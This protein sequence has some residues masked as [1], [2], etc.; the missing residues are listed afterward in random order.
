[1]T[2]PIDRD[3]RQLLA[4][5]GKAGLTTLTAQ[6]IGVNLGLVGV[7]AAQGVKVHAL[8]LRDHCR[9]A[10]LQ[11]EGPCLR[12]TARRCRHPSQGLAKPPDFVMI[13][14]DVAHH[15]EQDQMDKGKRI[16][17]QLKAPIR[18]IP[19]E[20]DWYLDMGAAWRGAT[21]AKRTGR[22]TTRVCTSSA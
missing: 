14:G 19:G 22:S 11:P 21:S 15:G 16:L 5:T 3:R 10:S 13:M 17:S 1:M 9:P 18:S 4:L 7:A 6:A 12:Q 8:P 2:H 20:H